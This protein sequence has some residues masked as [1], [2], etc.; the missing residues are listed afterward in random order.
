MPETHPES[1]AS[2]SVAEARYVLDA[3]YA[4]HELDA[5]STAKILSDAQAFEDARGEARS[6]EGAW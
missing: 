2:S 5:F 1:A 3:V 4:P 6:G